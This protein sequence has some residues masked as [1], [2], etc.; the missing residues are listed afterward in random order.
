VKLCNRAA[1]FVDGATI[2]TAAP[3]PGLLDLEDFLLRDVGLERDAPRRLAG[4][5]P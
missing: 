5:R 1:S 2:E 3:P 4:R